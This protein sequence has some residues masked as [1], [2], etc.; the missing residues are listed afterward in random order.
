MSD[1][2]GKLKSFFETT[3]ENLTNTL[4]NF[5]KEDPKN[6]V[7]GDILPLTKNK[8]TGE[9]SL[10]APKF[11]KEGAKALVTY[12]KGLKGEVDLMSQEATEAAFNLAGSAA[13]PSLKNI[14]KKPSSATLGTFVPAEDL[15]PRRLDDA[16]KLKEL[17]ASDKDIWKQT[18][19]RFWSS[20][21]RQEISDSRMDFT[22][23]FEDEFNSDF[24][25]SLK[26]QGGV[27]ELD[28]T[29]V[30]SH[31]ELFK[32]VPELKDIKIK[33]DFDYFKDK[34]NEFGWA[35]PSKK[36]MGFNPY[37]D[38]EKIKD[39]VLHELQHLIQEKSK[40]SKGGDPESFKGRQKIVLNENDDIMT[41]INP[42]ESY[43]NLPGEIEARL[44]AFRKNLTNKER[45]E[46][47]PDEDIIDVFGEKFK[48]LA[49]TK[50]KF[51]YKG[52]NYKVL[53]LSDQEVEEFLKG[54]DKVDKNPPLGDLPPAPPEN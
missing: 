54:Y 18:G 42:F 53:D 17:G 13:L 32:V 40:W 38:K 28:I 30:I 22:K 11:V 7:R 47:F 3:D 43:F 8:D 41:V 4:E 15:D 49:I 23:E 9:V 29:D 26:T 20:G 51:K 14:A 31:P 6:I 21:A 27:Y 36:E 50:N 35:N 52:K 37:S 45:R 33:L 5:A 34:P 1:I 48:A 46:R 25:E 12:D 19:T 10:G 24:Y 44:S 39:T 2:F 16:F